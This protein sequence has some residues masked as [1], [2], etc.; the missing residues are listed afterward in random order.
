M[1]TK[2]QYIQHCLTNTDKSHK[3]E[4]QES[5]AESFNGEKWFPLYFQT[6][7]TATTREN[8]RVLVDKMKDIPNNLTG[9]R[10]FNKTTGETIIQ[11]N[12][13]SND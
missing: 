8:K 5:I 3:W 13:C 7:N 4:Y 9:K 11:L 10:L 2:D 12:N 6:I 1:F